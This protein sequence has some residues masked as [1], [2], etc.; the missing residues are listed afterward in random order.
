M[1]PRG[2]TASATATEA[3]PAISPNKAAE[4]AVF[5]L[6]FTSSGYEAAAGTGKPSATSAAARCASS[7]SAPE[8][9]G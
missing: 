4:R 8:I 7:A 3:R 2:R 6:K 5:R 1:P 9:H